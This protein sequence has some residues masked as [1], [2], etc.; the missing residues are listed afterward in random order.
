MKVFWLFTLRQVK[1]LTGVFPDLTGASLFN[2]FY[3]APSRPSVS[4]T[5]THLAG[6]HVRVSRP[7][8]PCVR[9][10]GRA[11]VCALP[12]INIPAMYLRY[13]KVAS[14]TSERGR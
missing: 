9:A 13:M 14:F 6:A 4:N 2:V 11:R 5:G 12:E 8:R 3:R 1:P 10:H 7:V